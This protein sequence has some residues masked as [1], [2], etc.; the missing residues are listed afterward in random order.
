MNRTKT[1]GRQK[2]TPNKRSLDVAEK[3]AA[4]GCDPISGMAMIAMSQENEI[5]LR[6]R[7]FIELAQYIHPK[8]KALDVSTTPTQSIEDLLANLPPRP[9]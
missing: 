2:G 7:M 6:A 1:G 3:L 5:S 9:C 8:R 4:L